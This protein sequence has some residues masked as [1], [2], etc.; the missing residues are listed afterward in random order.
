VINKYRIELDG[1]RGLAVL[2][3]VAF[4]AKIYL[5]EQQLFSSG[6]LGVDVFFV[7]SGFLIFSWIQGAQTQGQFHLLYFYERRFRRLIPALAVALICTSF[8]AWR[9]LPPAAL[10]D[11]SFSMLYSLF[12]AANFYF[13][14]G[15]G[16]FAEE[17]QFQ[18]LLHLWSLSVE[19]QFYLVAPLLMIFAALYL[20]KTMGAWM[21]LLLLLSLH[22][23]FFM[24]A[25]DSRMMFYQTPFRMWQFVAGGVLARFSPIQDSNSN[26]IL[27]REILGL[28]FLYLLIVVLF[29]VRA[30]AWSSFALHTLV[31]GLSLGVI[32]FNAKDSLARK[33]LS[34]RSLVTIGLIS[35]SLYL[36]HHP[37]FVFAERLHLFDSWTNKLG[38]LAICLFYSYGVWRFIEQPCRRDQIQLK[39][40]LVPALFVVAGLGGWAQYV[41]KSEGAP[42][43]LNQQAQ[44]I[45]HQ[46]MNNDFMGINPNNN[47]DYSRDCQGGGDPRVCAFG[48]GS[49][50]T[51]GDSKTGHYEVELYKELEKS[52]RGLISMVRG[53]CPYISVLYNTSVDPECS[54]GNIERDKI[55]NSFD[56]T[57]TFVIAYNY[58]VIVSAQLHNKVSEPIKTNKEER[59]IVSFKNNIS[60]LLE[61]GHRVVIIYESPVYHG[62]M[63]SGL[64]ALLKN[65]ISVETFQFPQ[66]FIPDPELYS[67]IL[68]RNE[69][70]DIA[71]HH[72]LIKIYPHQSLCD[73]EQQKCWLYKTEGPVFVDGYHL[74]R[75]GSRGVVEEIMK[76]AKA[77]NWL[78]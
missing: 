64:F 56:S 24:E 6:F 11:Y 50:V 43:R 5:G 42:W 16:Y 34:L 29:M 9:F 18:P 26:G 10:S 13:A 71:E 48:D 53:G 65:N 54:M 60:R 59:L 41:I 51:L 28:S 8:M 32:F 55:I 61:K 75:V 17:E 63:R 37:V 33:I 12:F 70:L 19:E 67:Q 62:D 39:Y 77:K 47:P 30:E 44:D 20:R 74:S 58:E 36:I 73:Q 22:M 45:Y 7:V 31:T 66:S 46:I 78:E 68:E 57:K 40:V 27:L 21:T 15:K 25:I 23:M 52:S 35:Y 4:H 76:E 3:V 38:L 1:L 49:W 2:A 72:N 69:L 14:Q